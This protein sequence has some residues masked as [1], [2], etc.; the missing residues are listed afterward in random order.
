[1]YLLEIY[2]QKEQ[3]AFKEDVLVLNL[4]NRE[5]WLGAVRE[6]IYQ[7]FKW[8]TSGQFLEFTSWNMGEPNNEHGNVENCASIWIGQNGETFWN[9]VRCYESKYTACFLPKF[10][11]KC[12]VLY[13]YDF[14]YITKELV[15]QQG[16]HK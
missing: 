4:Q 10:E 16:Q 5:Y 1:M 9:D 13:N 7:S 2:S 3:D 15:R 8:A 11:R 12:V 6:P 14:L